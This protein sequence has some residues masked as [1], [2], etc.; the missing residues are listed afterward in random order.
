MCRKTNGWLF[1]NRNVILIEYDGYYWHKIKVGKNDKYKTELANDCG[2]A[3]YRVEENINRKIDLEKDLKNI[4]SL[5][6]N[7]DILN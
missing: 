5:L 1:F 4:K 6:S 2:Y 7:S 3:I